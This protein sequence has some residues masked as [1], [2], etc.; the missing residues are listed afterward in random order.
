VRDGQLEHAEQGRLLGRAVFA[1][2]G[3]GE[4]EQMKPKR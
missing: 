4:R 1:A 2:T 3:C